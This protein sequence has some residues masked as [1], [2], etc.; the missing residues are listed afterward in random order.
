MGKE[1]RDVLIAGAI[2]MA[3]MV[4]M[5]AYWLVFGYAL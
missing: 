4:G 5:V 3:F 1:S 2:A